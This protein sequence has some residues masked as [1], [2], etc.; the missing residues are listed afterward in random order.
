MPLIK[1]AYSK[2][3]LSP[4]DLAIPMSEHLNEVL[5]EIVGKS[6]DPTIIQVNRTDPFFWWVN[7]EEVSHTMPSIAS[8]EL[9]ILEGSLDADQTKRIIE[10]FYGVLKKVLDP[11]HEES[12]VMVREVP[13]GAMAFGGK[14]VS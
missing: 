11:L 8:V 9:F 3:N 14:P 7:G 6:D 1:V 12:C 13:R 4:G 5:D 10:K 2:P